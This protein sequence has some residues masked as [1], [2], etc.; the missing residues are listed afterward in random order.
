MVQALLSLQTMGVLMQ[1][2]VAGSQLSAVQA[3]LS[4]QF[5]GV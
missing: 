5:L 3:L 1:L 2:P 4:L